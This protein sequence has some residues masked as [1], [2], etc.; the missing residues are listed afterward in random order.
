MKKIE[1]V[2][3]KVG[4]FVEDHETDILIAIPACVAGAFGIAAGLYFGFGVGYDSGMKEGIKKG[5]ETGWNACATGFK[6][7]LVQCAKES[8][9]NIAH[10]DM[11]E[12][13]K[14]KTGGA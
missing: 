10:V 7:A 1:K 3:K 12:I 9:D 11:S 8:G 5:V 6:D 13:L 4:Q 14:I 2:K